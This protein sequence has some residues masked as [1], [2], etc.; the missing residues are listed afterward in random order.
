MFAAVGNFHMMGLRRTDIIY[1]ALP[2]YHGSGNMLGGGVALCYGV[3]MVI[4]KKFSASNFWKD[5]IKYQVTAAQYIGEICR[6][7]I[8]QPDS[9]YDRSHKVRMMFGNGLRKEI[10]PDFVK[11]FGIN[12][13]NELYGSTEGN[14]NMG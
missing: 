11:R 13:I 6:Y 7:L 12:Q 3:P 14:T 8:A 9:P 5:C 4:R 1:T 2:L 10:W